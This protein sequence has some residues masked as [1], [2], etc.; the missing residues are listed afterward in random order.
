M[1]KCLPH[2]RCDDPAP[3]SGHVPL[4][5]TRKPAAGQELSTPAPSLFDVATL[6]RIRAW[7]ADFISEE[8]TL[9]VVNPTFE[10]LQVRAKLSVT[11]DRENGAM[12]QMLR[13]DLAGYLSVWTADEALARFGWSLNVHMLRAH[14]AG[15]SYVRDVTDFSVLH[16]VGDDT[17]SYQLLDTAQAVHDP[18]GGTYG[19]VLTPRFPWSLPL[20]A[21]DHVLTIL[22]EIDDEAPS[23]AGIGN[24]T[25][26]DM[27]IVGQ[28]T[29]P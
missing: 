10:R 2:L 27:L 6:E 13:R 17:R 4:V 24:L 3:A 16:L 8:I 29:I 5:V 11:A 14:I 12:A 26:G 28:R 22:P 25:V 19:P 15:L 18:R 7:L 20:S 21:A 9:D 1:A 23:A